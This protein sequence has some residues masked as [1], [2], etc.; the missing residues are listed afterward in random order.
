V[1][2]VE[3]FSGTCPVDSESAFVER[4]L[5]ILGMFLAATDGAWAVRRNRKSPFKEN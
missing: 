4:D 3:H 1:V 2:V 5:L